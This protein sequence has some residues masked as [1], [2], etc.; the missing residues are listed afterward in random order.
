MNT[1]RRCYHEKHQT[2]EMPQMWNVDESC[3]PVWN[4]SHSMGV[5]QHPLQINLGYPKRGGFS[6]QVRLETSLFP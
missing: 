1:E 5:H 4:I 2:K 6:R 3:S